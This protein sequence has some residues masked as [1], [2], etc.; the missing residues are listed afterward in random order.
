MTRTFPA[1]M[2][3]VMA[4]GPALP[5][6][7]QTNY[8]SQSCARLVTPMVGKLTEARSR[9]ENLDGQEKAQEQQSRLLFE[10]LSGN[11]EQNALTTILECLAGQRR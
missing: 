5:G 11:T 9:L 8:A 3:L 2:A 4:I 6:Q 10:L 1:L 7:A